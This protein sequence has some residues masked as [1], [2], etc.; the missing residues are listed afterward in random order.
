MPARWEILENYVSNQGGVGLAFNNAALAYD[1]G[2]STWEASNMIQAYQEVQRLPRSQTLYVI[3]R[4]GRTR[5]AVWHVGASTADARTMSHQQVDDFGT[6]LIRAW[7]P[8]LVRM[9]IINP[10]SNQVVGAIIN[11]AQANLQLLAASLP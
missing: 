9:G 5:N 6:R 4:T 3:H 7:E 2:V 11:V 10:R 8:D 1:L